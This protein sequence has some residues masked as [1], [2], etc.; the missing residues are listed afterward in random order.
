MK[1]KLAREGYLMI[2]DRLSG[3]GLK[4]NPT[5]TCKHCHSIVVMNPQRTRERGYC[6]GCDSYIC[7]ACNAV[8]AKTFECR[9]MD[10]VIDQL[11]TA[12][13]AGREPHRILLP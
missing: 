1:T 13:E 7:D 9:T 2:D 12:A 10:R 3:G 4:E 6:R 5:Y 8:R 11:L